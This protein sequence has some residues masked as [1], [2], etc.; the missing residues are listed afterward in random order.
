MCE[1][2]QMI[3]VDLPHTEGVPEIVRS[4]AACVAS[5]TERH[6]PMCPSHEPTCAEPSRI[7]ELAAGRGTGLVSIANPARFNWPG[8]RLAVL[9]DVDGKRPADD[10]TAVLMFG[11]PSGVVLSPQ[12]PAL[13][14]AA[15]AD[16][17]VRE[18]YVLS[19]LDPHSPRL[20]RRCPHCAA[21]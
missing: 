1:D 21:E 5:V 7:G 6:Y 17:P 11:T 16:L 13:L 8:Y 9:D 12:D 18:G 14:G 19:G 10:R 3:D 20:V 2:R 15:A 4:F